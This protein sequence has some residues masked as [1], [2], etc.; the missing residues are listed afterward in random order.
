MNVLPQ[1]GLMPNKPIDFPS[2]TDFREPRAWKSTESWDSWFNDLMRSLRR[3]LPSNP[4]HQAN[5][6]EADLRLMFKL[7]VDESV[8]TLYEFEDAGRWLVNHDNGCTRDARLGTTIPLVNADSKFATLNQ[9]DK[10]R[11]LSTIGDGYR[12]ASVNIFRIK[13]EFQRARPFVV[14]PVL[15]MSLPR[16][17]STK[18]GQTPSFISGHTAESLLG[19]IHLLIKETNIFSAESPQLL[20]WA[21]G[22]GL[23]RVLAGV[24]FPS[25]NLGSW[26]YVARL[27][28]NVYDAGEA[29]EAFKYFSHAIE[30]C[31]LRKVLASEPVFA[32][33]LNE[34]QKSIEYFKAKV[35]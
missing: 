14:A 24:H 29:K 21:H 6:T 1:Y 19:A 30:T 13:D 8:G 9:Q 32:T 31:E 4:A 28:P 15:G 25:D 11:V 34:L 20:Q 2:L 17:Y 26:I 16:L 10:D 7:P 35:H 18:L 12:R 22:V 27:L 23:R 3:V 33:S 5:V